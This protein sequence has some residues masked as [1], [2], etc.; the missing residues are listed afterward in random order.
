MKVYTEQMAF[1]VDL[2]TRKLIEKAAKNQGLL[3]AVFVR[4]IMIKA[5]RRYAK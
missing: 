4:V 1:R 5:A 2:K 3:P